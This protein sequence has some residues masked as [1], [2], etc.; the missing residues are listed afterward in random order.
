MGA[1]VCVHLLECVAVLV[2]VGAVALGMIGLQK[3]Q[4]SSS[5]HLLRNIIFKKI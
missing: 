2:P 1:F 4:L 3:K 5:L